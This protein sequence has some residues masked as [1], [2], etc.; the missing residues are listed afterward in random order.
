MDECNNSLGNARMYPA[1]DANWGYWKVLV[2]GKSIPYTAL[3]Y[4]KGL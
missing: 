2:G 4:H 1:I 3:V